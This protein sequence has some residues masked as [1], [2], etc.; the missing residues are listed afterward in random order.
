[1][2]AP[3][4][5][6]SLLAGAALACS[7]SLASAQTAADPVSV[8]TKQTELRAR[9][10]AGRGAFKEQSPAEREAL[11]ASQTRLIALLHGRASFDALS[12]AER[13]EAA[14]LMASIRDSVA[15]A[16]DERKVCE[17]VRRIGSNRP[18][19]V[20]MTAAQARKRRGGQADALPGRADTCG[21]GDC[22]TE[23]S[24]QM[25]QI[26]D[27]KTLGLSVMQRSLATAL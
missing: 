26:G 17:Q 10:L 2:S 22:I 19:V 23:L 6:L 25:L 9:V 20:C 14:T 8:A 27:E 3:F 21:G 24:G 4:R 1:M 18:Q 13:E 16:E 15:R 12:P 11:A 5:W 7:S